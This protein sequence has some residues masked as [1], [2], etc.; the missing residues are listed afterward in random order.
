VLK[1]KAKEQDAE[2]VKYDPYE[3]IMI[4]KV[5]NFAKDENTV[6]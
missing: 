1:A 6:H 4:I 3:K 2:F 5:Q